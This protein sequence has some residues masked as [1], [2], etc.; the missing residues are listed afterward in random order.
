MR[1]GKVLVPHKKEDR[2]SFQLDQTQ[3]YQLDLRCVSLWWTQIMF[4]SDSSSVAD[5]VT[6]W[7][8]SDNTKTGNSLLER[9]ECLKQAVWTFIVESSELFLLVLKPPWEPAGD[10]VGTWQLWNFNSRLQLGRERKWK[11]PCWQRNEKCLH[12]KLIVST[13]S[14]HS[15][16]SSV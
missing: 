1:W 13:K 10:C 16:C 6:F 8:V 5:S 12:V 7:R 3:W 14:F 9:S 15:H 2:D 11:S 4:T